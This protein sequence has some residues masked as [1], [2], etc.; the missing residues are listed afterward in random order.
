MD[1]VKKKWKE[2][3]YSFSTNDRYADYNENADRSGLG[4]NSSASDLG[5]GASS[6]QIQLTD[7]VDGHES[8]ANDG[9]SETML[10]WRH[11]DAWASENHSDL[12]ATLSEPCTRSDIS[13]VEK[14]LAIIFPASVRASFRLHDGQEDL[15]SLTGTSGL[16]FGL[17]LMPLDQVVQMTQTWRNVAEN[18]LRQSHQAS[19]S[20]SGSS[21]EMPN[22]SATPQTLRS[23]GYGKLESQDYTNGNPNLQRDISHNFNKQFK[24]NS[25]P[26]QN[27]VPADAVQPNYANAGWIPLVT[28]NAGNHIA[29]DLAPGPKGIYGQVILFG[30]EFDTKYVV[31]DN[32]GDFLLS[33]ANDLEKGNWYIMDGNDDYLSGEGELVFRDKATKSPVMDYLDVLKARANAKVQQT[34]RLRGPSNAAGERVQQTNSRIASE[35]AP[36]QAKESSPVLVSSPVPSEVKKVNTEENGPSTVEKDASTEEKVAQNTE[37]PTEASTQASVASTQVADDSVKEPSETPQTQEKAVSVGQSEA[38]TTERE[39]EGGASTAPK[40][41]AQPAS[42]NENHT[43]PVESEQSADTEVPPE[44]ASV[45]ELKEEFETVAL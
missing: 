17:Q 2:L 4:R 42:D 36:A 27:S 6:S 40:D 44:T 31:A 3:I 1:N 35:T 7:F 30:R 18:M 10:A 8:S 9:V 23:K 43:S 38:T 15:E 33:F 32:W 26:K 5:E 14:D 13:N 21:V 22:K 12:Y 34:T 16:F 24:M 29:V 45:K 20:A 39:E 11:I 37:F 25:I 41:A 28:D 19:V